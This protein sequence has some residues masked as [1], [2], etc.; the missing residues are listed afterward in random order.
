[1]KRADFSA[2]PRLVHGFPDVTTGQ[3]YGAVTV[4]L[5]VVFLLRLAAVPVIVMVDL[6]VAAESL[7]V[8][9]SVLVEVVGLVLND[10][11]TPVGAPL[12]LSVTS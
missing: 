6:P 1:V 11:V 7:T 3:A 5:T 9:V 2:V 8:S 10:A 4:S 12:A